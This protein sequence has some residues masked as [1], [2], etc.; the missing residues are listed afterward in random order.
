MLGLI[1]EMKINKFL[2]FKTQ[3]N[4][5]PELLKFFTFHLSHFIINLAALPI[6]VELFKFEPV[7][8]QIFFAITVIISSYFWQSRITFK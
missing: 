8:A 5:I 7:L 1:E 2:V 3:G 6:L 4:Y